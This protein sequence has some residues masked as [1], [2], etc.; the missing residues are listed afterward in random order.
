MSVYLSS[1]NSAHIKS[2]SFVIA[3][4]TNADV[5]RLEFSIYVYSLSSY[6]YDNFYGE[7]FFSQ[8]Y[9]FFGGVGVQKG[10]PEIWLL[11]FSFRKI[12]KTTSILRHTSVYMTNANFTNSMVN[13]S[14][15]QSPINIRLVAFDDHGQFPCLFV[16]C[17]WCET[18]TTFL[19]KC[20]F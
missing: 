4:F 6:F 20:H 17:P 19:S 1:V 7:I 13:L 2:P 14:R 15:Q 12:K 9:L 18:N 11:L 10:R 3:T 5:F 16:P 8:V